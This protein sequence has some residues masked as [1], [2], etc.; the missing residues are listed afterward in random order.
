MAVD[1]TWNIT[2]KTLIGERKATVV[3]RAEGA[4]L[5]SRE[6]LLYDGTV[7]GDAVSWKTDV[8]SPMA[9]TLKFS[10]QVSGDAI[11][12]HAAT[13]FGTWPFSGTRA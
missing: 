10:G 4:T 9:L 11:A 1:G 3:L 7:D 12:G 2:L 8:T 6:R 13:A 5:A